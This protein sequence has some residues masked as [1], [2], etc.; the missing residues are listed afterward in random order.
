LRDCR[1]SPSGDSGSIGACLD[2]LLLTAA[3]GVRPTPPP[4]LQHDIDQHLMTSSCVFYFFA[5][6]IDPTSLIPTRSR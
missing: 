1:H 4:F 5:I 3:S 2:G 6:Y